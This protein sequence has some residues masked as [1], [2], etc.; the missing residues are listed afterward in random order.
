MSMTAPESHKLIINK[1]YRQTC[2]YQYNNS[3]KDKKIQ[4][5]TVRK[6]F[7]KIVYNIISIINVII[8]LK[9]VDK[10]LKSY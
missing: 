2:L 5:L 8:I 9:Q 1:Y 3:K 7:T 4:L 10:K 6:L